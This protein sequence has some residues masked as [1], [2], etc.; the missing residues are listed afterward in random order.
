MPPK[1]HR[2]RLKGATIGTLAWVGWQLESWLRDLVPNN[3]NGV[4]K[5]WQRLTGAPR[6]DELPQM[7]GARDPSNN[8]PVALVRGEP[9]YFIWMECIDPEEWNEAHHISPK[10]VKAMMMGSVFGWPT[11]QARTDIHGRQRFGS[12]RN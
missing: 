3:V 11:D 1:R 10:Q 12:R 7:C 5:L 8:L 9:G 6:F 4:G 2:T